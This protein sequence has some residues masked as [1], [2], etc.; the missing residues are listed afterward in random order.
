MKLHRGS[1]DIDLTFD[2]ARANH[3]RGRSVATRAGLVA[4][5]AFVTGHAV[6]AASGEWVTNEKTL[7]TRARLPSRSNT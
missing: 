1:G 4:Q 6:L 5:A 7:L 2:Y 3:A